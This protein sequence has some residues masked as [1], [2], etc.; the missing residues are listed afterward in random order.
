[1]NETGVCGVGR[2][3]VDGIIGDPLRRHGDV[4]R[5]RFVKA[6]VISGISM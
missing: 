1:M 2:L 3:I 4:V 6:K 5:K